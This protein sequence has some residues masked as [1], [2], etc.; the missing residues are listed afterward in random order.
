MTE[1][2]HDR[3]KAHAARRIGGWGRCK[4]CGG[5]THD[6]VCDKC[7]FFVE[8]CICRKVKQGDG[9]W[10]HVDRPGGRASSGV[11]PRCRPKMAKMLGLA[12][13]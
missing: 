10:K 3:I 2:R 12:K 6:G 7:E 1:A 5:R 4:A 8:C 13:E 11:C 9:T